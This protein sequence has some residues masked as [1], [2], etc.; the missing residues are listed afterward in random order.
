[1]NR[2]AKNT[3]ITF[4]ILMDLAAVTVAWLG[5]FFVRF[6]P[7]FPAP[8][9]I[10]D[11]ELYAKL[12]PFLWVLTVLSF[13]LTGHYQRTGK[14]RTPLLES[15]DLIPASILL[16]VS[17]VAFSYFYEE[18]RYSR[19]VTL[20]FMALSPILLV[21]GRS[22]IRKF[23]RAWQKSKDP[24]RVLVITD[25]D[26]V[27][28]ALSIM[29]TSDLRSY[30]VA[31]V[32]STGEPFTSGAVKSESIPESW[33]DYLALHRI[34]SVIV[35]VPNAG[36]EKLSQGLGVMANQVGSLRIIPDVLKYTKF[37]PGI[38]LIK[39]YPVVSLH[40]SPLSGSGYVAKRLFD[41]FGAIV[42]LTLFSP[43]M[44]F[45]SFLVPLSSRGPILY[46]QQRMGLD[47][48]PFDILKFRSMPLDAE[49]KTGAVW[50]QPTDNRATK[51]GSFMRKT[52]LDE[53]PQLLNVLKGEMSLVGPRPE[54][55][56][57]VD[58]F[59]RE[60]PGYMLRHKVKAGITGWAQVN[61]WR[62]DTSLEKRIEFDL[63][64]IQNWS[65]L[66]D[67]KIILMTFIS[68]F[69]NKNAY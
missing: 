24:V 18:Y 2:E 56:V 69:I 41:I 35:A 58:Q 67:A 39:G 40:E 64:Y 3:L 52:S 42:A 44:I 32:I 21:T 50:A 30:R 26:L 23:F 47:G 49:K 53:L 68:G 48:K 17:F 38:D 59:R 31:K 65:I 14:H 54:R 7:I 45:L 60:I 25:Q 55:P 10:P 28:S 20:V 37:T 61:G 6:T 46:R 29:E 34:E 43:I 16:S 33:I 13:T 36:F 51:L 57:F 27:A 9:G 62:G 15:V 66:L 5:S 11:L 8:K 12:I 1:M 4:R 22:L 19:G 63:Y